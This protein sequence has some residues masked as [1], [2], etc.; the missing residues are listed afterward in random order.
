MDNG[1][2]SVV[3]RRILGRRLKLLREEFG[4]TLEEAAPKLDWSTSTLSRIENGQQAPNVHGMRSMM[5]LYQVTGDGWEDLLRMTRE[6]RRK[7]WW[8]AYGLGDDAYVGF[9]AEA[10]RV[11]EFALS[12]FPGLL[13]VPEYSRALFTTAVERTPEHLADVMQVRAIRQRRLTSAEHPLELV[14]VVDE[15]V[16]HRPIGGPAVLRE[17]LAHVV[18]AAALPSVTLQVLPTAVGAHA[19]IAS[20]LAVLSF[21]H[22]GEP[23]IAYVEHTL[24][25]LRVEKES[26]VRRARIVIDRL[27]SAALGPEESLAL[28]REVAAQL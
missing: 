17:Q 18:R 12:F 5:D 7:G 9:E 27:R 1:S 21:E 6:V 16:L 10:S 8:R 11:Q 22:L 15:S 25:S 23:D 2:G 3:H 20:P 14:T 24:G 28:V 13:Q 4:L 26:E 19:G